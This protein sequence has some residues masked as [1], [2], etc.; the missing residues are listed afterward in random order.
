MSF[1]DLFR[2]WIIHQIFWKG[3]YRYGDGVAIGIRDELQVNIINLNTKAE[4]LLLQITS[5][6]RTLFLIA[7]YCPSDSRKVTNKVNKFNG[8]LVLCGDNNFVNTTSL[9][10]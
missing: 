2:L 5:N 4:V 1:W 10:K 8:C 7:L 9:K 3:R 6:G